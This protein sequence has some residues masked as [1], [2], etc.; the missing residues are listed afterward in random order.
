M[1]SPLLA[2]QLLELF[3]LSCLT[4]LMSLVS[5]I[6]IVSTSDYINVKASV[7]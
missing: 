5:K 3:V 7:H 1:E 6:L 4:R 2:N